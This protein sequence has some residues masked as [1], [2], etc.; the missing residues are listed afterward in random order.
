[1]KKTS[2]QSI[3]AIVLKELRSERLFNQTK[4]SINL[5]ISQSSITKIE[6]GKNAITLENLIKFSYFF[7]ENP[8]RIIEASERY[9]M[10]LQSFFGYE[11]YMEKIAS[12]EDDFLNLANDFYKS[13][14]FKFPQKDSQ[15]NTKEKNVLLL[16]DV[17]HYITNESYRFGE[18]VP[19]HQKYTYI[20]NYDEINNASEVIDFLSLENNRENFINS[21]REKIFLM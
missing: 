19:G 11:I 4:L 9:A 20:V 6:T 3:V 1:M 12:E 18:V 13:E 8:A 17:F 16:K 7:H 5:N 10:W 2:I 15:I 14:I 21:L